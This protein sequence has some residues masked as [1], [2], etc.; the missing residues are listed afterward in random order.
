V[1]SHIENSRD[2]ASQSK[3]PLK[4]FFKQLNIPKAFTRDMRKFSR[5]IEYSSF[6]SDMNLGVAAD[7]NVIFSQDSYIPRS[8]SANLT[9]DA[10]GRSYNLIEVH[11]SIPDLNLSISVDIRNVSN[12]TLPLMIDND[13]YFVMSP[14]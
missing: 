1:A 11:F 9:F 3:K 12:L 5:N 14:L 7:G 10:Y 8:L 6:S 4:D 13:I 2:S